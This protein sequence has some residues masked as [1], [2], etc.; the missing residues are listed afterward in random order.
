MEYQ[1]F[2]VSGYGVFPVPALPPPRGSNALL[3]VIRSA[4]VN[5]A[6]DAI[7]ACLDVRLDACA[8]ASFLISEAAS[9]SQADLRERVRSAQNL[10]ATAGEIR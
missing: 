4:Q 5:V 6:L 1:T 3:K 2:E 10:L 7:R 9:S 8:L